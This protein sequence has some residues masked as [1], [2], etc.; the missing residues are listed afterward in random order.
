MQRIIRSPFLPTTCFDRI[1][2]S[3]GVVYLA[4]ISKDWIQLDE[5]DPRFQLLTQEEIAAG[6]F[7]YLFPSALPIL[8]NFPFIF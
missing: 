7:Y 4:K 6:I 3:S 2:P 1:R 8:L 5:G